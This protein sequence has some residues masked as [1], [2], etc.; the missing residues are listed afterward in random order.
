MKTITELATE[1]G[2]EH[3]D[4]FPADYQNKIQRFAALLKA[5]HLEE[6]QPAIIKSIEEGVMR[7]AKAQMEKLLADAGEM[8]EPVGVVRM[9]PTGVHDEQ[10]VEFFMHSKIPEVGTE[11]FTLTQCQQAVAAAVARK[12]AEL[13]KAINT[14]ATYLDHANK[15]TD[16]HSTNANRWVD[17]FK[18]LTVERDKLRDKYNALL[19]SKMEIIAKQELL[20][21]MRAAKP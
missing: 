3:Y 2:F 17:E 13:S 18:A 6:L 19:V 7:G 9:V 20:A 4:Q 16:R 15:E 1:A 11:L 10:R 8:P 5:A 14:L 21:R 12:D